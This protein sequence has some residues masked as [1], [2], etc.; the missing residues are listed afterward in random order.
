MLKMLYEKRA[1][2]GFEYVAILAGAIVVALIVGAA[3]KAAAATF[4]DRGRGAINEATN[5]SP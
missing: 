4:G 1:Q 2:G 3:L 5:P